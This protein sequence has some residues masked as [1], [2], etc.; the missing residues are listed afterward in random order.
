MVFVLFL[1]Q[2][3]RRALV[4]MFADNDDQDCVFMECSKNLRKHPHML[5]ECIPLER[6]LGDMA[7]IYFKVSVYSESLSRKLHDS[8]V[9][10]IDLINALFSC[11]FTESYSR[12]RKGMVSKQETGRS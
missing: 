8:I 9:Y 10:K 3:F 6:E 4:Q 2:E 7:P 5:I 1:F 12:E 11:D